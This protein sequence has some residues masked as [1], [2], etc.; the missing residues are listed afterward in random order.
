[1]ICTLLQAPHACMCMVMS[2]CTLVEVV[3]CKLF[4]RRVKSYSF[5]VECVRSSLLVQSMMRF[6]SGSLLS[7]LCQEADDLWLG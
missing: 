4:I 1:M 2:M 6:Y 3:L 7:F 5:L